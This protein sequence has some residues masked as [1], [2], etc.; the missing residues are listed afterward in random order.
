MTVSLILIGIALIAA[1]VSD[2][3]SMEIP[4]WCSVLLVMAARQSD[5]PLWLALLSMAGVWL[6]LSIPDFIA[7][8]SCLGG[9]DLKLSAAFAFC[10]GWFPALFGLSVAFILAGIIQPI[11]FFVRKEKK[12]YPFAPYLMA[13]FGAVTILSVILS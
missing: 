9:G 1:C 8:K 11:L 5:A 13:G 10:F 12:P 2:L 7:H 3:K 6:L 4:D